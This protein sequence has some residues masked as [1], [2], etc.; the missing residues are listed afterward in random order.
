MHDTKARY[1]DH[2]DFEYCIFCGQ[3][4]KRSGLGGGVDGGVGE[5]AAWGDHTTKQS[6]SQYLGSQFPG[7]PPTVPLLLRL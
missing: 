7:P 5:G 2:S 1:W 4:L 6:D 3:V